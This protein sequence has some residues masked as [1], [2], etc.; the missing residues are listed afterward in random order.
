MYREA[1]ALKSVP[2]PI[3]IGALG[4]LADLGDLD[5]ISRV[6][7]FAAHSKARVRAEAWRTLFILDPEEAGWRIDLLAG[8]P[9]GKVRRHIPAG[10]L[11]C[12]RRIVDSEWLTGPM[13]RQPRVRGHLL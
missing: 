10:T 4:G 13:N 9:N 6:M 3:A 2:D 1:L 7:E 11:T 12:R 5:D 8:D